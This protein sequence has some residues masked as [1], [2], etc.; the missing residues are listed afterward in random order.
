MDHELRLRLAGDA[1]TRPTVPVAAPALVLHEARLHD[2]GGKRP[3][4][5]QSKSPAPTALARWTQIPIT[6]W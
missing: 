3:G 6:C 5:T 2:D 4:H 1:H